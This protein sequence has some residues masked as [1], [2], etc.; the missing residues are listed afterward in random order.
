M[1]EKKKGKYKRCLKVAEM[2]N[3]VESVRQ[4]TSEIEGC[5]SDAEGELLYRLAKDVPEGQTIV[6]IGRGKDKSTIWLAKG[7]EAG[8]KNK[9]YSITSHKG[10]PDH[11]KVDE[12]NMHTE[13]IANLTKARVQ[14]TVVS[15]HETS[16]EAAR[17]W[18]E[19][20][21][22]LWINTSH[23]YEDVKKVILSWRRHL[24]PNAIVAVHG[25]N[26]PGPSQVVK[27][28]LG[29]L[30]Y[31]TFEQSVDTAMVVRVDKCI[32][33]WIID[34][35]EIG[36]CKYCGRKRNFRRLSREATESETEKRQAGK[37]GK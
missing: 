9:V 27:E 6:E 20:I 19:K 16:E 10:S 25:C 12:E 32:H 1:A 18:K 5:I 17:R 34:S 31:F 7:S 14:D 4:L 2:A 26:Q 21:G 13:F 36:I 11:V 15:V 23:E 28:C 29:D 3:E 24:Y 33:Y 37:K 8:E 30:G 22:L 35:N